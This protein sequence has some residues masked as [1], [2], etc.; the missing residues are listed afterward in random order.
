MDE[1]ILAVEKTTGWPLR[2]HF[3]EA[4]DAANVQQATAGIV[5]SINGGR[6][7][8]AYEPQLNMGVVYGYKQGGRMLLLRDYSGGEEPLRLPPSRLGFLILFIGGRKEAMSPRGAVIASLK[9]TVHNWRRVRG[10]AG[11]GEY[12]YGKAAFEHWVADIG[13]AAHFSDEERTSLCGVSAWNVRTLRD[14]RKA[15]VTSLME[16]AEVLAG[17]VGKALC[18]AANLYAEEVNLLDTAPKEP[19][20]FG[21]S[22]EKWTADVRCRERE[23]LGR[24]IKIEE[25]ALAEAEQALQCAA[26]I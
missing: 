7:V 22:P 19:D 11:P 26:S 10:R 3:L 9:T 12:W 6:A 1:E 8:L 21:G 15:A 2:V 16:S 17:E 18:R 5:D 25:K 23:V 24:A 4:D 13:E 20:V 14:A